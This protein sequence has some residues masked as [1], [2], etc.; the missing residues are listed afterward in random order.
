MHSNHCGTKCAWTNLVQSLL[1]VVALVGMAGCPGATTTEFDRGFAEGFAKDDEYYSGYDDSWFTVG[2]TP[3]LYSGDEIPFEEALTFMAG[4]YDGL[5]AAY[6]DGYF[7]AY[8]DAFIIGFSEGY[9]SAFWP[10]YLL[11]LANDVH[12]EFLTGGFSDG[13]EDGFTEGRIFG[14]ADFEGG[15]PFDWLDGFVAWENGTDLF[16]EEAG[17]GTGDLGPAILYEWGTD[18]HLL[19][20]VP[21]KRRIELK[22]GM[23]QQN[24]GAKAVLDFAR[25]LTLAQ[26]Q[27]LSVSPPSTD[28]GG[29]DLRLTT[30]WLERILQADNAKQGGKALKQRPAKRQVAD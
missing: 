11:F 3:I 8:H 12:L 4:F 21:H 17:V 29:T 14:A 1:L 22:R 13:Y 18:P 7:V 27:V 20:K 16:F 28:R 6:N 5:F 2:A 9:D 10:D 24:S 25:P 30:T 15:L 23:R 26:E 19:K